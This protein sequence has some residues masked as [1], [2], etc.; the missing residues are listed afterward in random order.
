MLIISRC[1]VLIIAAKSGSHQELAGTFVAKRFAL[2]VSR[3]AVW[4]DCFVGAACAKYSIVALSRRLYKGNG[5][6]FGET[7]DRQRSNDI[8]IFN[9]ARFNGHV[10]NQPPDPRLCETLLRT[11]ERASI[12]TLLWCVNTCCGSSQLNG[13]RC[14]SLEGQTS[15]C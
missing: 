9:G 8:S 2:Q 11:S 1:A 15:H 10:L 13:L 3:C 4:H 7:R 6:S 14:G 5:R 12:G